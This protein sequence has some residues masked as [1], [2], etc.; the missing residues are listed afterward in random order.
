MESTR[1]PVTPATAA[2]FRVSCTDGDSCSTT[3]DR[4]K[5]DSVCWMS[6]T[7]SSREDENM[8]PGEEVEPPGV[9]IPDGMGGAP[10][11]SPAAAR[12]SLRD[13]RTKISPPTCS[14]GLP[15]LP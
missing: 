12:T 5:E 1:T 7:S 2:T 14:A 15:W 4:N 10:S 9:R 13:R 6:G 8:P 11:M 3:N